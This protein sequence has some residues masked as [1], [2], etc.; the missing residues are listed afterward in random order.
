MFLFARWDILVS[1]RI[2]S[3][4]RH[5]HWMPVP[6]Y[7]LKTSSSSQVQ[8]RAEL[9]DKKSMA[10]GRLQAKKDLW[11][12]T[13]PQNFVKISK[14]YWRSSPS[15]KQM[16]F[17]KKNIQSFRRE[18]V[19]AFLNNRCRKKHLQG[20]KV[21]HD[22]SD[23]YHWTT[24]HFDATKINSGD[25]CV[26]PSWCQR[27]VQWPRLEVHPRRKGWSSSSRLDASDLQ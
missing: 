19:F 1:G 11:K 12:Y 16:D 23:S 14:N 26:L 5:G 6:L 8:L 7:I 20:Y 22:L 17:H 4:A 15:K 21:P 10:F 2:S 24:Q 9:N 25:D 3:H 18:T 13:K 27:W